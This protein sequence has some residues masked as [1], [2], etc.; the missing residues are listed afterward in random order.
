MRA[1]LL[2]SLFHPQLLPKSRRSAKIQENTTPARVSSPSHPLSTRLIGSPSW[3]T[4]RKTIRGTI[5]HTT[6]KKRAIHKIDCAIDYKG[7]GHKSLLPPL[8]A[9]AV[10][11]H[12]T[13]AL[14]LYGNHYRCRSNA[15]TT[16]HTY[17]LTRPLPHAVNTL[18]TATLKPHPKRTGMSAKYGITDFFS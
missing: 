17:S 8:S 9:K 15:T 3:P 12:Y 11:L 2:S 4:Y 18:H 7:Q 13:T 16:P 5:S 14:S 6:C 10:D 1:L